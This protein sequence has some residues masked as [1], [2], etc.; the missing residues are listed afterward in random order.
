MSETV[1]TD[2]EPVREGRA[3]PAAE[4][5]LFPQDRTCPYLPP[6]GYQAFRDGAP[7]RAA[8]LYDG[9]PAWVVSGY[10][11]AR[12][13]LG[14]T[15]LSADRMNPGYPIVSE[16]MEGIRFQPPSFV[17]MDPPDHTRHR[18]TMLAEFSVRSINAI[19]PDIAAIVDEHIDEMLARGGPL[20]LV[21]AFSLPVPSRVICEILGVPY[22][23][24]TFFQETSQNLVQAE[25]PEQAIESVGLLI[26]YFDE[27]ISACLKQPGAGMIGRI[28]TEHVATDRLAKHELIMNALMLLIAGHET[29]ASMITLGVIT[30]LAH[31]E[32]LAKLRGDEALV[33]PAVEELLRYLSIADIAGTR[34]AVADVEIGGI[35]VKRGDSLVVSHSLANRDPSAF[36]DP[37]A[38]DIARGSRHHLAFG[39]GVH[40]CLGQN[41]ARAELQIALPALFS[42]IPDLRLA[43]DRSDLVLRD[44]GTVQGVNELLITWGAEA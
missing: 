14:G 9:S 24:H 34:V 21:Q 22:S 3:G 25:S 33:G 8:T 27:L 43:V 38:F 20:D 19:R 37:D 10:E 4:P 30:L 26:A 36:T 40:Q 35:T 15:A 1:N 23:D 2:S 39:Y 44:G 31:P 28:A 5:P 13:L 42:R 11:A 29:T 6:S 17:G 16:R 41:L 32:Q 12:Q 18:R 7:V